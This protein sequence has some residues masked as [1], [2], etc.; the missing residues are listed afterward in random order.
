[1]GGCFK[2]PTVHQVVEYRQE[3]RKIILGLIDS[4]PLK[5]PVTQDD[6][7]VRLKSAVSVAC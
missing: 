7:L 1:M 4:V 5:M 2:W 6:P 3:V